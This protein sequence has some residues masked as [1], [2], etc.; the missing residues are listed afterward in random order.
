M[1]PDLPAYIEVLNLLGVAVFAISGALAAGSRR[2]DWFGV[3]VLGVVVAIGGGTVRDLVL[4]NTP[5]FWVD[6]PLAVGIAAGAALAAIYLDP[7]IS[8]WPKA[9]LVADAA[10]LAVFTVIGANTA[11]ALGFEGWVAVVSGVLTGTFGGLIRD[12][13]TAQV[14]LILRSEVYA[15]A[16]LLGAVVYVLLSEISRDAVVVVALPILATFLLR[17]A[18]VYRGWSLPTFQRGTS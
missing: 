14:P 5:V 8:R 3:V 1:N 13:L 12:V 11:L 7:T 16:S 2:L 18:A 17:L 4:G 10:G 9:M 15:T 6:D